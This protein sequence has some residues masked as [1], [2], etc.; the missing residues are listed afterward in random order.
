MKLS[1]QKTYFLTLFAFFA[2]TFL[3]F[4]PLTKISA[5]GVEYEIVLTD[6]GFESKELTIEKGNNVVF[7]NKR[8]VPVWP[9]SD[10]HPTH[11]IYPELDPKRGLEPGETWEFTFTKA[12]TWRM[13]DHLNPDATAVITVTGEEVVKEEVVK[14]SLGERITNFIYD[15]KLSIKKN[16]Y[17]LFPKAMES[18][19]KDIN[20]HK[21]GTDL[22]ELEYY[23]RLFGPRKVMDELLVD[24]G[25]GS[26][27]DCHQEAHNT[28]RLA[29]KL[30][31]AEVFSEGDS[32]CHSG[33]YHGAMEE[34]LKEEGTN[35]LARKID[36]IC[37]QF[38][39]AYSNFE[40]LHGV[41]HGVMAYLDYD[42]LASLATCELLENDYNRGSC[43]G[44]VFMENIVAAQGL[45]AIKGHETDWV[46]EDPHFP[47]NGVTQDPNVQTECYKMQTSWM[48][49][50]FKGDF[51]KASA[52]C[53]DA[54][55]DMRP[56]CFL[57]LGRDAAGYALRDPQK[58]LTY[59]A[60]ASEEYTPSCL[61]GALNVIVEFWG[62]RLTDEGSNFCGQIINY[63]NKTACFSQ[64]GG[65]L[66]EIFPENEVARIRSCGN[67]TN[68]FS[69]I[70]IGN[71]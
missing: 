64:L 9:A 50:L 46:S 59:C 24:S 38:K 39:T 29:Y 7:I 6:S 10:I 56:M 60:F 42:M 69:D 26:V 11:G 61:S 55:A 31:G 70:C 22:P 15:M 47:C 54:P 18:K 45:G 4:T 36:E 49:T 62:E 53:E 21:I 23:L 27:V 58:I 37:S 1:W 51:A 2:F 40:C 5:H 44:G 17:K 52:A 13:H 19:L 33:F 71:I 48:L 20:M 16:Y 25:G 57:S 41:G 68:E 66:R 14:L 63:E 8:S 30:Y 43:Y 3:T 12:G 32:S 35:D 28:G 65:R 34:F 67:F